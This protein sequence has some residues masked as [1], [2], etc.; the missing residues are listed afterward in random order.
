ME[1]LNQIIKPQIKCAPIHQTIILEN[2]HYVLN[3][4][5]KDSKH[6]PLEGDRGIALPKWH[7]T[8]SKSSVWSY[9]SGFLLVTWMNENLEESLISIHVTKE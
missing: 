4:I 1:D 5:S 7:S 3:I 6:A 2:L 9:K 8:I